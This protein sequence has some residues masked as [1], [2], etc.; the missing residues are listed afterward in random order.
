MQAA[1]SVFAPAKINLALHVLG[2]RADGYHELDSIVAFAGVGDWL[3]FTPGRDFRLTADGPLPPHFPRPPATSSCKAWEAAKAIAEARGLRLP[4]AAVHLTKNLP[5]A[6]GIGGG[7]ANAA[8]ALKG[9]LKLAGITSFDAEIA[10]AAL[11]IGADVPVCL[12]GVTC[13]MQ[14]VGERITPIHG[15]GPARGHSGQSDGGGLDARRLRQA[16][17]REGPALGEAIADETDPAAVAKRPRPAR[18]RTR[19][20]HRRGAGA[21]ERAP[22][23]TRAFMSGSGATCVALCE[24]G[25][26]M[27]ALEPSWWAVKTVLGAPGQVHA[28]SF[29]SP[30][31]GGAGVGGNE[32]ASSLFKL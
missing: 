3:R 9:F 24:P 5:V 28:N 22:G 21:A 14:G 29:P 19:A 32:R 15:H 11:R 8:A 4:P 10:A 27:P 17:P 6:S 20:G 7:S 26:P 16:G 31:W 12:S 18:H 25:A 13:R 2:R 30:S 1:F 23:V